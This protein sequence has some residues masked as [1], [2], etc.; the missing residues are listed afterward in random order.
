M[1][2]CYL[3]GGGLLVWLLAFVLMQAKT[4]RVFLNATGTLAECSCSHHVQWTQWALRAVRS[5]YV[6][7]RRTPYCQHSQH[8]PLLNNLHYNGGCQRTHEAAIYLSQQDSC[9]PAASRYR[10]AGPLYGMSRCL[11]RAE[12]DLVDVS[13]CRYDSCCGESGDA[14]G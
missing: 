14:F 3:G 10:S 4:W 5:N 9:C 12:N 6:L 13:C 2:G 7:A 1:Q 8:M 11:T